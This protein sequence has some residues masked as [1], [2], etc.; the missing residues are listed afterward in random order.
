MWCHGEPL[1]RS[2]ALKEMIH[3]MNTWGKFLPD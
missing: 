3:Y 2:S 1:G